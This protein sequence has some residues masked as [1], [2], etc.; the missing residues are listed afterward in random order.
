MNLS[1]L[2]KKR[3]WNE[4]IMLPEMTQQTPDLHHVMTTMKKHLTAP[5]TL[6][7]LGLQIALFSRALEMIMNEIDLMDSIDEQGGDRAGANENSK[8]D[9]G[10]RIHVREEGI[11]PRAREDD[12]R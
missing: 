11:T 12:S 8:A 6:R 5:N 7:D 4:A 3:P 2:T 9:V 10:S 1:L